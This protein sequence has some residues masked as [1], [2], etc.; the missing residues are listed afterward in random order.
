MSHQH[1]LAL[2]M[3]V[4]WFQPFKHSPYSVGVIYLALTN[5]PRGERYQRENI[6]VVGIIPGPGEPSSLNPYLVPLVSELKELW[7]SGR[8]SFW[9]TKDAR[10]IFCCSLASSL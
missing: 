9:L 10:E 4:D 6:I 5:L 2:M 1:N 3:N 8:L 7:E